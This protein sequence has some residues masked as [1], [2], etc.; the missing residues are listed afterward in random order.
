MS[1]R[2]VPK[3]VTLNDLER[4]S[5][6]Y[7]ARVIH[8]WNEPSPSCLYS[9]SIHQMAPRERGSAHPIVAH[10]SFIDL[11]RMKG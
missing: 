1:F 6:P 2:L 9:V 10:Y 11:K 8:E 3:S 7:L 5:G 4:R